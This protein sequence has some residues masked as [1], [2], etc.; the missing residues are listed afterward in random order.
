M[1]TSRRRPGR[2]RL[3]EQRATAD[4]I[5]E[6]ATG[7]FA[8]HGFDAVGVRDIATAAG[9]DV[10][11]VHHHMGTKAELYDTCFARVFEAERAALREAAE[12]ASGAVA[13]YGEAA[14]DAAAHAALVALH[15]LLD[16]FVDFLED[17]PETTAL[18]LRR[19]LEPERHAEF[20]A[21]YATPLYHQVEQALTEADA[22][23]L[24]TEPTAHIAVRSLVWAVHA[25]VV[26]LLSG[27]AGA[28]E[29]RELRAFLHRWMDRMYGPD[30]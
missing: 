1:T 4:L 28:R 14:G 7:L 3:T 27:R 30:A 10:S 9:V 23:G 24:L 2:P 15:E 8:R 20:D 21:R 13:A 18:W 29:R 12:A 16:A 25:H 6:A 5:V 17:R 19:W 26:S 11:T 22:V